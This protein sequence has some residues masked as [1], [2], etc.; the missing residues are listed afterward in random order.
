MVSMFI[1]I[2]STHVFEEHRSYG[3]VILVNILSQNNNNKKQIK[4]N[5]LSLMRVKHKVLLHLLYN[6]QIKLEFRTIVGLVFWN[7]QG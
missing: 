5:Q 6:F 4:Q 2:S 3:Q 1:Q 7:L